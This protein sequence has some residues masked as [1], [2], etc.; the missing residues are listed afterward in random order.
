M[1][2][3]NGSFL[4]AQLIHKNANLAVMLLSNASAGPRETR[5]KGGWAKLMLL[6]GQRQRRKPEIPDLLKGKVQ[7]DTHYKCANVCMYACKSTNL[8]SSRGSH[9]CSLWETAGCTGRRGMCHPEVGS[10]GP[11]TCGERTWY[12][13]G[14]HESPCFYATDQYLCVSSLKQ[15]LH[16]CTR[17]FG[18]GSWSCRLRCWL[19]PLPIC[20]A[21]TLGVSASLLYWPPHLWDQ[22]RE[23]AEL[24][25]PLGIKEQIQK[26][27]FSPAAIS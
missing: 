8:S 20:S 4:M 19:G 11:V 1:G 10:F 6:A 9:P 3:E 21:E 15:R 23:A 16:T 5:R 22:K 26:A 27:L 24:G 12:N 25:W 17:V 2:G 14:K 18:D 7:T 13:N